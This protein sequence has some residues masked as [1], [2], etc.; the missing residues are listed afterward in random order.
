MLET[1]ATAIAIAGCLAG[2]A[3]AQDFRIDAPSQTAEVTLEQ[4][5]K[6]TV[7]PVASEADLRLYTESYHDTFLDALP[8]AAKQDFISSL[9]FNERGLTSFR[10]DVLESNL[11]A[12]EAYRLL[13][14][15]GM[16]GGTPKL[17]LKQ[18]TAL[19]TAIMLRASEKTSPSTPGA[20][21]DYGPS[22]NGEFLESYICAGPG[23]C[24]RNDAY[25]CTSNC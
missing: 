1:L 2:S 19:D 3:S 18:V 8:P 7:V 14:H 24:G 9:K 22:I 17:K 5:L 13:S 6:R 25:A 21:N 11:S 12:T 15:F 20:T 16:E 23:S 4:Q 10:M